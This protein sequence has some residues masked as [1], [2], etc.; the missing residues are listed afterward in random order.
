MK[1]L[2]RAD[3]VVL[4]LGIAVATWLDVRVAY[5]QLPP[6]HWWLPVPLGGLAVA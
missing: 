3:L 4:A 6:L 2:R 1:P 5:G